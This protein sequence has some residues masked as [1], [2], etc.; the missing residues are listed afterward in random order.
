MHSDK[1]E[2]LYDT[3]IVDRN[4]KN[5][6]LEEKDLQKHLSSLKDSASEYELVLVDEEEN[7][8]NDAMPK[9]EDYKD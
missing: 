3:R 2:K 7:C 8:D 5:G 9:V 4:I 6:L 1:S